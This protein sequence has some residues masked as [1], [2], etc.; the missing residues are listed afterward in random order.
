MWAARSA[1]RD[2]SIRHASFQ[3]LREDKPAGEVVMEKPEPSDEAKPAKVRAS[4]RKLASKQSVGK[5]RPRTAVVLSSPDK[6]LWPDEG[7]TKQD[8][9]DHYAAV[10]PRMKRFV[11]DRPLALVR[12]PDGIGGQRFFQKHAMP[13]MHEAIFKSRDP[14]DNE[15]ILFIRDF[16]GVAALVQLGVVEIHIWGATVEAIGTPD[17]IVFDLD[18]DEGLDVSDVRAATLDVKGRLD[19]LG[20]PNFLKTSGGKGFHVIVPLQPEADWATVKTFAHDFARAMEQTGPDRYT[21]TLSKKARRGRIF[22]D[23]LRNGRGSTTVAPYSSRAK[24]AATVSAPVPWEALEGL[25]PGEFRI[26]EQK[27]R[28]A[29]DAP[30]PWKDYEKSRETLSLH[31]G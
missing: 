30:D 15:E 29:L 12:A 28:D 17:Q 3:G 22:I 11:V 8:L 25:S 24:A 2:G 5:S 23:Y 27:L 1:G 7:V 14:E 10:W 16:D 19:D 20:L 31:R 21:A 26:G 13:G 18:P 9:L 6:E 4:G